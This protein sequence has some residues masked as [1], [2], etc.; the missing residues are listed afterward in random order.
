MPER[1]AEQ[2]DN[3]NRKLATIWLEKLTLKR[4]ACVVM[5]GLEA[6]FPNALLTICAVEGTSR[7]ELISLLRDAADIIERDGGAIRDN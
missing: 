5:L 1:T 7:E 6:D 2:I 3:G 4:A